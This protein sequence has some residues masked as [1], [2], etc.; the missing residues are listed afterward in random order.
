MADR[1]PS[2]LW[3]V[4]H[5]ESSGNVARDKALATGSEIIELTERDIDVPLSDLGEKQAAAV[6]HWFAS[7][8]EETQPDCVLS[9]PYRRAKTTAEIISSQ[10]LGIRAIPIIDER[11]R[12]K[13]FGAL[14]RL[15]K[16]GIEARFPQE[17]ELRASV[18]KFY[19]RPPAGES[20]CDVVL[21]LRSAFD[22]ICLRHAGKRVLI[23]GHQVVVLCFRYLLEELD[24]K[25]LL[26]IDS[27]GEVANCSVTEYTFE[28]G[29]AGVIPTLVRYNFVAPLEREGTKV[30]AEPDRPAVR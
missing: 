28:P 10:A 15:T 13:E 8:P 14:N 9:S 11:L 30:T 16:A 27:E 3:L 26:S 25:S 22:S 29:E 17:A 7:L 2:R 6:G 23:V 18:G 21:R 19:Y 4:R 12:E 5:G 1:F 24:E 20:W